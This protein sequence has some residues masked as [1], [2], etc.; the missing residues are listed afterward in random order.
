MLKTGDV[1]KIDFK[2]PQD[3]KS[4]DGLKSRACTVFAVK[5]DDAGQPSALFVVPHHGLP[6]GEEP[7]GKAAKY[8]FKLTRRQQSQLGLLKK[9]RNGVPDPNQ[10]ESWII[11]H[12]TNMVHVP[13]NPAVARVRKSNGES[14]WSLGEVPAGI[15]KRIAEAQAA[16]RAAGDMR[17]IQIKRETTPL[18]RTR[19]ASA[20]DKRADLA[21]RVESRAKEIAE[22]K[23]K[24][25]TL[26]L[27]K[28]QSLR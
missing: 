17:I 12:I 11:P 7:K 18:E 19:P 9:D 22:R 10:K 24:K 28:S 4:E 23:A 27:K 21:G 2:W 16:A 8:A 6:P 13:Q 14:G 5:Q 15:L 1:A 26:S 25:P 20:S 3:E